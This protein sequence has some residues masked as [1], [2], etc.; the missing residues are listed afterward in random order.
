MVKLKN[1]II[2]TL[3]Y[4]LGINYSENKNNMLI[5]LRLSTL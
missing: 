3:R 2:R 4:D 5:K 1:K